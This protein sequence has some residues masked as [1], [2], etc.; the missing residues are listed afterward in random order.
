MD[1]VPED[2]TYPELS[3][4]DF[5]ER[6]VR[7]KTCIWFSPCKEDMRDSICLGREACVVHS[8]DEECEMHYDKSDLAWGSQ[9]NRNPGE[10][11]DGYAD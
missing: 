4:A 11:D 2:I 10:E 1:A 9:V 5:T 7:C 6:L 8:S 3:D